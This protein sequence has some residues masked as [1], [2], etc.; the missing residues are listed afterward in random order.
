MFLEGCKTVGQQDTYILRRC[1]SA[2][3]QSD[4]DKCSK[5]VQ[6]LGTWVGSAQ[7][8]HWQTGKKH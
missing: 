6:K 2:T 4:I 5:T 7:F 3:C 8:G 1:G